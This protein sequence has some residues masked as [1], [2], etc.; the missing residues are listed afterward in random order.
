MF[1]FGTLK[2]EL[3][4]VTFYLFIQK[5]LVHKVAFKF[6]NAV[7]ELGILLLSQLLFSISLI[8]LRND[9]ELL[10]LQLRDL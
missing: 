1:I 8:A 5:L 4:L 2:L 9:L 7:D 6:W 3:K 10:L